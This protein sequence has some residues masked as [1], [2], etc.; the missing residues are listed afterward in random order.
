MAK[1]KITIA[2]STGE[3][4][5]TTPMP[6]MQMDVDDNPTDPLGDMQTLVGDLKSDPANVG[7][8]ADDVVD[9]FN[10]AVDRGEIDLGTA[11]A[12][13]SAY[14]ALTGRNAAAAGD[15]ALSQRYEQV[16]NLKALDAIAVDQAHG[17]DDGSG[18]EGLSDD[19]RALMHEAGNDDG[20]DDSD[21]PPDADNSGD[22][23]A[24]AGAAAPPPAPTAPST[25]PAG[26][27]GTAPANFPGAVPAGRY[28]GDAWNWLTQPRP[29]LG[30]INA[31]VGA[32]AADLAGG[33]IEA[34]GQV[35]AG[36]RDAVQAD[37]D[38]TQWAGANL[39]NLARIATGKEPIDVQAFTDEQA[40]LPEVGH[41]PRTVT[42]GA[43]RSAAQFFTEL[44]GVGKAT[45]PIKALAEGSAAATAATTAGQGAL[46]TFLGFEPDQGRISDLFVQHFPNLK[47]PVTDFLASDPNDGEAVGRFKNALEGAGL[48]LA[49]D[50]VLKLFAAARAAKPGAA[51]APKAA[52]AVADAPRDFVLLG[53]KDAPLTATAT[54]ATDDA[55]TKIAAAAGENAASGLS[56]GDLAKQ[57]LSPVGDGGVFVNFAKIRSSG[58]IQRVIEDTTKA[59]AGAISGAARGVRTHA[60]TVAAAG[61]VDAFD[62]LMSRRR[63]QPLNAEQS[64]AARQLWTSAAE[65]LQAVA[66]VA[67]ANPS[68][69][70]LFQF[71]SMF[72]TFSAI[73]KEVIGARSETARAL[74]AWAIPVG[75]S[76][77]QM[78]RM[79]TLLKQFGGTDVNKE[80]AAKVAG[81]NDLG[82]LSDVADKS[83]Y[84]RSR[85]ALQEGW[86]NAILSGPKTHVRN[87]VSNTAAIGL[88]LAENSVAARVGRLLGHDN[89]VAVG[90]ALANVQGMMGAF[91]D[92]FRA[93]GRTFRTGTTGF[94]AG[95]FEDPRTPAISADAWNLRGD[96]LAGRAVDGLGAIVRVP[97]RLLQSEDEWFKT[98]GYRGSLYQQAYRQAQQEAATGQLPGGLAD[99]V[100]FLVEHPSEDMQLNAASAA[101]YQTFTQPGGPLV[102]HLNA[103][104]SEYPMLR[105]VIP[106]VSTPANIFK[107]TAERTPLAPLTAKYQAA[108]AQGG[109]PADLARTKLA[110][111][112][113]AMLS[114]VDLGLSGA[115]TGSGPSNDKER[116]AWQRAG[117][118]PYSVKIGDKWVSYQGADP[119]STLLGFGA[120]IA[121]VMTNDRSPDPQNEAD[122]EKAI[123]SGIFSAAENVTDKSYLSGLS[124]LI[125]SIHDPDQSAFGYVKRTAGSFVPRGVSEIAGDVDPVQREAASVLD[126]VKSR[127]PFWSETLPAQRDT[128]GRPV[129]Y[130][131]PIGATYDTLSPFYAS[132]ADK[133]EPIDAATQ[134]DG[135]YLGT[136]AKYFTIDGQR[137]SLS[138]RPDIYSRFLE[139]RGQTKAGELDKALP[140]PKLAKLYGDADLLDVLNGVAAGTGPLGAKYKALK[141]AHDR[142]NFI[143]KISGDFQDAAK[144]QVFSEFPEILARAAKQKADRAAFAGDDATI[145]DDSQ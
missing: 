43:I 95:K 121:D 46:A 4:I 110:L 94:G 14:N 92:A 125:A 84:A 68:T 128:W 108:I 136:P 98:I 142:E 17:I 58:D 129:S 16:E 90:E 7:L 104:R 76:K 105:F 5:E 20:Y 21:I 91:T 116:D 137:V 97:G 2:K 62:A 3:T 82:V 18:G 143:K 118:L 37:L 96:S 131:S 26:R 101:A 130:R 55:A 25:A 38:F 141:T 126:E 106:F 59:N 61:D 50:G 93:A 65:K 120:D 11:A 89:G 112:T 39:G 117:G 32:A 83:L 119:V 60:E 40:D 79:D 85:D 34:P 48:G 87:M 77:W 47:N 8:A 30:A 132:Q 19:Q 22:D 45:A 27:P 78:G 71:R 35:V 12:L 114:A 122:I 115:T 109:A 56:A 64:V 80:L 29:E 102:Q 28:I 23:A 54:A 134:K 13:N 9:S 88:T 135:W 10:A 100:Q 139:L 124:D 145:D 86:I 44:A 74:N 33:A 66:K 73:Q 1:R 53:S 103:L 111:G 144:A 133:V 36:A 140:K 63:G 57:G 75:G 49:S 31:G 42:G 51:A 99:R 41:Q 15:K 81:L 138:T 24:G 123:V 113:M 67:A 6:G 69:E 72:A 52:A 127:I 70:N 107:F